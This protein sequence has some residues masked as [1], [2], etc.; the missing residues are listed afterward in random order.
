[1]RYLET[2]RFIDAIARA[3]SIRKA[4][5]ALA[6]T[7]SAL[8]RRIL[9][10][11]EELGVQIF[12]RLSHGVRLSSAGEI[13]VHAIR[14]QLSDIERVKSQIAD[15]SGERRGHIAIACSQ[16]L[17]PYF[18]P[19]QIAQYR[20]E[21]PKVTFDVHLRDRQAAE[22][23]LVDHTAD[24]AIVFEPVRMA[25]FHTILRVRQPVHAV[26]SDAHPLA[27]KASVRLS[28]CLA[29][30][31]AVPTSQYGVRH[32]L[33]IAVVSAQVR[34][35]PV[36]ESDS[37]EFLRNL[38]VAENIISF[39]IPIG[40]SRV[41]MTGAMV[42]RPLDQRDVPAGVLYMGQLRGRTLSVAAARF[43]AQVAAT[44]SVEYEVC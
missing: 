5:D 26:M 12:E 41:T 43:A 22:R 10:V 14:N 38:A 7:S 30:P 27:H 20:A 34:L 1:V 40:L 44:L 6:I 19:T 24:L 17:L 3:G 11:E 35:S 21:H 8:N 32:L 37:F 13:L 4:A 15:L 2:A 23:A 31:L 9:A 33:D 28:D 25:E 36:I 39:Q 16:A 42:S 29:Y 18:L